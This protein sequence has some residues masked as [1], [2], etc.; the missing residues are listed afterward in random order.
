MRSVKHPSSRGE[1]S[2]VHARFDKRRTD[3]NGRA[4]RPRLYI[5]GEAPGAE[6]AE[7]GRPFVGPAGAAL[8]EMLTEARVDQAQLRLANAVPFRPLDY[9][10]GRTRS[11]APTVQEIARLGR[12]ALADIAEAAPLVVLALGKAAARLF[13][14]RKR[15]QQARES[16]HQFGGRPLMVTYHPAYVRR[17]GGKGSDLWRQTVADIRRAWL[18]AARDD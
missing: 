10:S 5:V 18:I 14:V 7:Q 2:Q 1:L 9:K 3:P 4:V 17:F 6:E 16:R 11:R 8:R 15:I 12:F 13:G